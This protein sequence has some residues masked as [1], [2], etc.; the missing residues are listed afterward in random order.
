MAGI[1]N[2]AHIAL[3]TGATP[4]LVRHA[5]SP[6]HRR[7]QTTPCPF[8]PLERNCSSKRPAPKHPDTP[9]MPLDSPANDARFRRA[10]RSEFIFQG[11]PA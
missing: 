10:P 9:A 5:Q 3:V 11:D 8:T 1:Y 4:A 2:A 6:S 7:V